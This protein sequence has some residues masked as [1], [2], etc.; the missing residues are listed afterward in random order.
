MVKSVDCHSA[1]HMTVSPLRR[2]RLV[3]SAAHACMALCL[4][5]CLAP[6]GAQD[7]AY[8]VEILGA[9]NL[10]SLLEENLEIRRHR[11]TGDLGQG[12]LQRLVNITPQQI[13]DLLATEG[14]FSPAIEAAL[15][16]EDG[17]P[18]ARFRVDPGQ[19]TR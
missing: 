8:A 14:Y 15:V 16:N 3:R 17:R 13:R 12:E 1:L 6:A 10:T 19:P 18:V 2:I 5:L 7:A 9:G 4:A 11:N